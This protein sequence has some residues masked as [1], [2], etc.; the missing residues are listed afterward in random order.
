MKNFISSYP[1]KSN[2][3]RGTAEHFSQNRWKWIARRKICKKLWVIPM[4]HSGHYFIVHILHDIQKALRLLWCFVCENT[5]K[6]IVENVFWII[7]YNILGFY[8]IRVYLV[9]KISTWFVLFV[10]VSADR[11]PNYTHLEI[12]RLDDEMFT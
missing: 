4:N 3:S 12:I 5:I 1:W 11:L 8:C 7:Y 6:I 10:I 2:C 9:D